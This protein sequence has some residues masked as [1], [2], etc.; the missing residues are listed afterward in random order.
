MK[1]IVTHYYC[2]HSVPSR[3]GIPHTRLRS[4]HSPPC[5]PCLP[6]QPSPRFRRGRLPGAGGP[7]A[8]NRQGTAGAGLP[9]GPFEADRGESQLADANRRRRRP[10]RRSRRRPGSSLGSLESSRVHRE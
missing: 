10:L 1:V 3:S 4:P 6:A 5:P 2:F 8:G 9:G 7:P